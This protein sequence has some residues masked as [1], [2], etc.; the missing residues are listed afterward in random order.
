[1][2]RGC[3]RWGWV[4]REWDHEGWILRG[5]FNLGF[6]KLSIAAEVLHLKEPTYLT[7]TA[8]LYPGHLFRRLHL[9]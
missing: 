1:M 4:T 3:V 2:I 6:R 8:A 9:E 7:H 5:G